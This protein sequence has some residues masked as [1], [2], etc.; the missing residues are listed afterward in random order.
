MRKIVSVSLV[1]F[2]QLAAC[3][4]VRRYVVMI[5][6]ISAVKWTKITVCSYAWCRPGLNSMAANMAANIIRL[7]ICVILTI[8]YSCLKKEIPIRPAAF[9]S[10]F[11]LRPT[12]AWKIYLQQWMLL[13]TQPGFC[14][15]GL[16]KSKFFAQKLSDL[17]S[18]LD[19]LMQLKRVTNGSLSLNI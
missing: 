6:R 14:W 9:L 7:P 16:T 12:T 3:R 18:V 8:L 10:L 5:Y 15:E 19:K 1:C 13:D 2:N 11:R 17:G 4:L